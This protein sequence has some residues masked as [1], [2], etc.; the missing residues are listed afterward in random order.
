MIWL[1]LLWLALRGALAQIMLAVLTSKFMKELI[2][3]ALQ[4]LAKHT[5]NDVDDKIISIVEKAVHG[6]LESEPNEISKI[7]PKCGTVL[8]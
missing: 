4:K 3:I 2:L 6:Q 8:N 1:N 7:C 5:D